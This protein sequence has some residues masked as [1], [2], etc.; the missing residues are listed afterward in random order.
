M[1]SFNLGKMTLRSL[2]GKP[3]TVMYPAQT[4]PQPKGL[5]GHVVNDIRTC[6]LCGICE[7]R[8]PTGAI[9]VDKKA[10]TWTIDRFRCVQCGSCVREC[11]KHSLS[12]DPAHAKPATAKGVVV[13]RKPEPTEEEKAAAAAKAAEREARIAAAKAAKAAR[14]AAGKSSEESAKDA[15]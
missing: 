6:I 13:E 7:K 5:K 12:M 1:G 11:P 8:C 4:R 3:E 10:Q 2:F 15:E 9:S 14:E